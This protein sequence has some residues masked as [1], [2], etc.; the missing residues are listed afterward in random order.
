MEIPKQVK[1]II[2]VFSILAIFFIGFF[3]YVLFQNR[4]YGRSH[5]GKDFFENEILQ[6]MD[7]EDINTFY[8][9][10]E[11]LLTKTNLSTG[12][13]YTIE[14]SCYVTGNKTVI[15]IVCRRQN[16]QAF[17]ENSFVDIWFSVPSEKYNYNGEGIEPMREI[18]FCTNNFTNCVWLQNDEARYLPELKRLFKDNQ[19]EQFFR[20]IKKINEKSAFKD[21][22]N[23]NDVTCY[24]LRDKA[25][26][27]FFNSDISITICVDDKTKIPMLAEGHVNKKYLGN[28][29]N[30]QSNFGFKHRF[31]NFEFNIDIDS[32]LLQP[33]D[34]FYL[35]EQ[36][37]LVE[38][39]LTVNLKEGRV[40][41][42]TS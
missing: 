30:S 6:K 17:Y 16:D 10:F 33:I 19:I 29:P 23:D 34:P 14:K 24:L 12:N 3:V 1:I 22:I 5:E 21:K 42:R 36:S 27:L 2:L 28:F 37:K 41:M 7:L 11:G 9:E 26:L 4:T 13:A 8:L 32:R 38:G 18:F 25:L 35:V 31:E 15:T 39:P 20:Y 40:I